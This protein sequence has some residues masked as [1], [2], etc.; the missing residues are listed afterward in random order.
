VTTAS[1]DIGVA[2]C[3]T[4][5]AAETAQA[6]QW[7]EDALLLIR[8][9]LGDSATLDQDVLDYVVREAVAARFRNPEGYQSETIDDYTYRLPAE[10]RRITILPEWW[11]M[12]SPATET[13]AYSIRPYF[14]PDVL[15]LTS[16]T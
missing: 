14:E 16:W 10:T 8:V 13:G 1:T 15:D 12:L 6:D 5:T 7:I 3:R 9:R 11:E 2:L 4:L